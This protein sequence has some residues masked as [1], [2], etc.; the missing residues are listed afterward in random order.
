MAKNEKDIKEIYAPVAKQHKLPSF[1]TLN[2]DFDIDTLDIHTK[3]VL[4]EVAK[5]IF[6]RIEVFKKTLEVILQPDVSVISM[7][8]S[9]FL[10]DRDH[11]AV[12]DLLRRLMQLDRTLLVAEVENSEKLYATFIIEAAKEWQIMKKELLPIAQRLQQGWS[13]RQKIKQRQHHYVG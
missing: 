9:E 7:M 10:S 5:K 2:A 3:H 4:K 8:E 13:T 11:D 12:S 1:D 6:E